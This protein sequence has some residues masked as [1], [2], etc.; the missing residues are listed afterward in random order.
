VGEE[1]HADDDPQY[2]KSETSKPSAVAD[3][4][5]S[6]SMFLSVRGIRTCSA[7]SVLGD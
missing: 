1:G 7:N 6:L 2:K 5:F 3:H 4:L